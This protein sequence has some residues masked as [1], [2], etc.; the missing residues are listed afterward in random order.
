[1]FGYYAIEM[2]APLALC[3]DITNALA[4]FD[5]CQNRRYACVGG[6][7]W[8]VTTA[9][10]I[11]FV[12]SSEFFEWVVA[13]INRMLAI[14]STSPAVTVGQSINDGRNRCVTARNEEDGPSG[15]ALP[16]RHGRL[17]LAA[18]QSRSENMTSKLE[19][20]RDGSVARDLFE[21][22]AKSFDSDISRRS[23]RDGMIL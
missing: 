15:N 18:Q 10:P 16:R 7:P 12:D 2:S 11:L 6:C 14:V 22:K 8:R 5:N 21:V 19:L 1:L 17:Q 13:A 23:S 20:H 4:F 3:N 9:A